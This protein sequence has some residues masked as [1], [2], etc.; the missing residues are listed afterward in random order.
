MQWLVNH[1]SGL[2]RAF[3][4]HA[5]TGFEAYEACVELHLD[6]ASR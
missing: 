3:I 2:H 1:R 6:Y 4:A 5:T